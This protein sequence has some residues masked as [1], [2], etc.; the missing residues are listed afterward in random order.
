M[1]AL[2]TIVPLHQPHPQPALVTVWPP[3]GM[4][5]QPVS[6]AGQIVVVNVPY[7]KKRGSAGLCRTTCV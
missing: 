5:T 4:M 7:R 2:T 1:A 6:K 3:M